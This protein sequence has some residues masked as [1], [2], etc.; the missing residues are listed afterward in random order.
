MAMKIIAQMS[1]NF[2]DQDL[3]E[4]VLVIVLSARFIH[5]KIKVGN[6]QK[7]VQSERNSHYTNQGGKNLIDK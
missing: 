7:M 5:K 1:T 2:D 4:E 3:K 6:D